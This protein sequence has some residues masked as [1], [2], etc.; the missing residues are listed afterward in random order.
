MV[1][2]GCLAAAAAVGLGLENSWS[3]GLCLENCC[4]SEAGLVLVKSWS[5]SQNLKQK[6]HRRQTHPNM[7]LMP[8]HLTG[9]FIKKLT[10]QGLLVQWLNCRSQISKNVNEIRVHFP[11]TANRNLILSLQFF[12]EWTSLKT[13]IN[14]NNWWEPTSPSH[15][16]GK[17]F[18]YVTKTCAHL[19]TYK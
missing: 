15:F 5:K 6:N 4:W 1:G 14:T 19:S 7:L 12:L 3:D 2:E 9:H 11:V 13:L 18:T 16:C 17:R 10:S 8:F